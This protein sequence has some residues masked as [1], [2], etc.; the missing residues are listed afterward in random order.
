MINAGPGRE[1]KFG[2]GFCS[3]LLVAALL[4]VPC[5]GQ[6]GSPGR[7]GNVV[8]GRDPGRYRNAVDWEAESNKIVNALLIGTGI[9]A[10]IFLIGA[11]INSPSKS[12]NIS[13]D[14]SQLDFG[15]LNVGNTATL[16]IK[17][18]NKGSRP[19]Q[20]DPPT[21]FGLGFSLVNPWEGPR[22][23]TKG[24]QTTIAVVFTPG[25]NIRSSGWIKAT[26]LDTVKNRARQFTIGLAGRSKGWP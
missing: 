4:A 25:S 23:L 26:A 10:G 6:L 2:R 16:E 1:F 22:I 24:Q 19:V 13:F 9:V 21:I 18:V 15:K 17:L 5:L 20:V 11:I 8:D 7:Y 3:L 12:P 14:P